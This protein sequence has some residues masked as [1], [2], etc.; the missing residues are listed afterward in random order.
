MKLINRLSNW[1]IH[2]VTSKFFLVICTNKYIFL[3]TLAEFCAKYIDVDDE[4]SKPFTCNICWK[5][6]GKKQTTQLHIEGVHFPGTFQYDC[7]F[8]RTVLNTKKKL[9][10]HINK[11]CE[12]ALDA[13]RN[14]N[15][16]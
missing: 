5:S 2:I 16:F 10:H 1:I 6:F 13:K 9:N 3:G 7:Y 4:S 12:A 15:G 11:S 8:C 14:E